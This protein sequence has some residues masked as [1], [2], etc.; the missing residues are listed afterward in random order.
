MDEASVQRWVRSVLNKGWVLNIIL[1][2]MITT[3]KLVSDEAPPLCGI[4]TTSLA[5]LWARG[6]GGQPSGMA[7]GLRAPPRVKVEASGASDGYGKS[8]L[9][10]NQFGGQIE[11][12]DFLGETRVITSAKSER[13]PGPALSAWTHTHTHTRTTTSAPPGPCQADP[14]NVAPLEDGFASTSQ[15]AIWSDPPIVNTPPAAEHMLFIG[16]SINKQQQEP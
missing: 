6:G 10:E 1:M 12:R 16:M 2:A 13:Q 14:A 7:L 15:G 5:P 4:L 9:A 11:G 8:G 3:R